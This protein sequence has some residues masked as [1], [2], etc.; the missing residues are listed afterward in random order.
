MHARSNPR[1]DWRFAV[2]RFAIERICF[3]G[4]AIRALSR[5]SEF[6]DAACR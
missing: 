4:S 6:F 5:S 2:A 3:A 1:L